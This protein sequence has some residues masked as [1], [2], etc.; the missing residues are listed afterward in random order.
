MKAAKIVSIFI[1]VQQCLCFM[2]NPHKPICFLRLKQDFCVFCQIFILYGLVCAGLH[3][4]SEL[5]FFNYIHFL[6]CHEFL[7]QFN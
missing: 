4:L 1:F 6:T 3:L 5:N 2:V 7:I